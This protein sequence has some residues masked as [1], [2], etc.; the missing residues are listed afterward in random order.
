[1][2]LLYFFD[3]H[4][5][6]YLMRGKKYC[7]PTSTSKINDGLS[8]IREYDVNM[9][10]YTKNS[11]T[12]AFDTGHLNF[13][14]IDEEFNK[15]DIDSLDI[16]HVFLTH[17]D[18][19]HAGGIDEKGNNI[20]PNA[21]VYLGKDEEQYIKKYISRMKKFGIKIKNCV[22]IGDNYQLINDGD[23]IYIDEI[24]IEAIS[25]P[26]HTLGHMCY[27]VDDK[28]LITGDCLAVNE[29]G[30]YSFFDFFTQFPDLNKESLKR[31]KS[32]VKNKHIKY[33]C[34][35]HSGVRTNIS[36]L[37]LH[38]NESAI[39]SRKKPFDENGP[40]DFTK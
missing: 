40:W 10:F 27:L 39:F 5:K 30:G 21:K 12:I 8:C 1:M 16:K 23:I 33:I 3:D 17:A 36:D 38:I 9:Y 13:N 31:L 14:S 20:F 37:F 6:K 28:I 34:T 18:V 15:I 25:V 26:G 4:V 32:K 29:N 2:R 11:T 19:D 24:K 35:G 22:D 7:N